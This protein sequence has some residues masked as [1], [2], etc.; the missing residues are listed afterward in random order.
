MIVI[1]KEQRGTS[2]PSLY[3]N[4]VMEEIRKNL[5]AIRKYRNGEITRADLPGACLNSDVAGMI[6]RMIV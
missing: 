6:R 4:A 3:E 5:D 2:D 1:H